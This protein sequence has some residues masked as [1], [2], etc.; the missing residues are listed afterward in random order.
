MLIGAEP[1]CQ[2]H[3][4][5]HTPEHMIVFV[6]DLRQGWPPKVF[7]QF[8]QAGLALLFQKAFRLLEDERSRRIGF[9]DT[10][11]VRPHHS[12]PACGS[13]FVGKAII[14]KEFLQAVAGYAGVGAGIDSFPASLGRLFC[15]ALALQPDRR[16]LQEI[17]GKFAHIVACCQKEQRLRR[18][19]ATITQA[20][21][22]TQQGFGHA[23]HCQ[24]VLADRDAGHAIMRL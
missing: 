6:R 7:P 13:F 23:G 16:L 20:G 1:V 14:G 5:G 3:Q 12:C 24:Q 19:A 8:A 21:I 11:V 9:G 15:Q 17:Q 22:T 4:P 18:D 2:R 10:T